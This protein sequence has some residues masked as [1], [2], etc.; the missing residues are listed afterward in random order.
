LLKELET[1][2][3]ENG[4]KPSEKKAEEKTVEAS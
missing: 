1:Q 2:A 4:E 3:L